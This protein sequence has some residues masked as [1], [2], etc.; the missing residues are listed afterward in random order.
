LARAAERARY[1]PSVGTVGDLRADVRTVRAGF[2]AAVGRWRRLRARV[3]P[4]ST[5]RLLH[6]GGERMADALDWTDGRLGAVAR[7]GRRLRP[8]R[9]T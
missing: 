8:R 2:A 3:L 5:L 7:L 9:A 4:T 1:A 6:G